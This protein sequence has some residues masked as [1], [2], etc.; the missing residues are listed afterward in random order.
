[1]AYQVEPHF[2]EPMAIRRRSTPL[3]PGAT[4]NY[5]LSDEVLHSAVHRLAFLSLIVALMGPSVYFVE[6]LTQ[7]ERIA[8]PVAP[9]MALLLFVLGALMSG[10]AWSYRSRVDQVLDVGLVF[11]VLVAFAI[12]AYEYATPYPPGPVRGLPWICLWIA[13]FVVTIPGTYG[14]HV[15]AALT[16]AC[17]AP[18]GLLV[19]SVVNDQRPATNQ[20]PQLLLMPFVTAAWAIPVARYLYYLGAQASRAQAMGSYELIE[21]IGKGG[22]GEV[23]RARHRLLTRI[24]AL[25]LIR[26]EVLKLEG[27]DSGHAMMRRF[28][29]EARATATLQSPHTVALYDY[30][31]SEDGSF[32]YVMELLEGLDLET[33]VH[34]FGP[35]PA[36]RTIFLLSQAAKSLAEAHEKG[37][38]HRDI[39]PRNIFVCRLGTDADFVKVL[40]FGLVKQLATEETQSCLTR[41]G[42]TAGTP[43]YMAPEVVMGKH[44]IDGRSDI[45]SLGCVGYWLLTGQLVFEEETPLAAAVAH[46]QTAPTLPSRRTELEIPD[47]L[48]RIVLQCLEKDPARRPQTARELLGLLDD[49]AAA[50][51]WMASDAELWWNLHI[52]AAEL[53]PVRAG[54][55]SGAGDR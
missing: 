36:G 45:Y 50:W 29:R 38:I 40:D 46:V 5:S 24:S 9:A 13:M 52:P 44:D 42:V 19:A 30:G 1:M 3:A 41:R 25:K 54:S 6:S 39:K 31:I 8:S 4:L 37:M 48:E 47:S 11:Q 43:Q 21:L 33:L 14:K 34:R 12:S 18:V 23:W 49:C 35:L 22:M 20:L 28:E 16:A 32:F 51:P 17:M 26:P 7:P 10:W 27:A 55:P 15:L 53:T 2:A